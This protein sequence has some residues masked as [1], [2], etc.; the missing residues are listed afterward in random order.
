MADFQH[1]QFLAGNYDEFPETKRESGKTLRKILRKN[2]LSKM[3]RLS[4]GHFM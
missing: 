3:E 2:N 1:A 4:V